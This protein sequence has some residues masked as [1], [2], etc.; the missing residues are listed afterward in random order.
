MIFFVNEFIFLLAVHLLEEEHQTL[1]IVIVFLGY[2][3]GYVVFKILV[4]AQTFKFMDVVV[5]V[6]GR[7]ET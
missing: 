2:V 4:R 3:Y 1:R 6:R 7:I 5:E